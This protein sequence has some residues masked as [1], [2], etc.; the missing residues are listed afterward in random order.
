MGLPGQTDM[1]DLEGDR[2]GAVNHSMVG[3]RYVRDSGHQGQHVNGQH[4]QDLQHGEQAGEQ[5]ARVSDNRRAGVAGERCAGL[6]GQL[7][8]GL[9]GESRAG[10]ASD[11][12]AGHACGHKAGLA[13]SDLAQPA[14]GS[15]AGLTDEPERD[16]AVNRCMTGR[17]AHHHVAS[18]GREAAAEA[19]SLPAGRA[20]TQRAGEARESPG[21]HSKRAAIY[22]HSPGE[23]GGRVAG[24]TFSP[25]VNRRPT[26]PTSGGAACYD[27]TLPGE[28]NMYEVVNLVRKRSSPSPIRQCKV[29]VKVRCVG[30]TSICE[31]DTQRPGVAD[32]RT[33]DNDRC[34]CVTGRCAR[35]AGRCTRASCAYNRSSFPVSQDVQS[36]DCVECDTN[37][38]RSTDN[39]CFQTDKN[40]TATTSVTKR[41]SIDYTC[42]GIRRTS[43]DLSCQS[44]RRAS[45]D[46][47][48]VGGRRTSLDF[49]CIANRRVSKDHSYQGDRRSSA[50]L[51]FQG[52]RRTS[53]DL[54]CQGKRHSGEADK[55]AKA[56]SRNISADSR[57]TGVHQW[58][59]LSRICRTANANNV[60]TYCFSKHQAQH[61][62]VGLKGNAGLA[63][64]S[65]PP[66]ST[67][68]LCSPTGWLGEGDRQAGRGDTAKQTV[69]GLLSTVS[70]G[71]QEHIHTAKTTIEGDRSLRTDFVLPTYCADKEAT[72][73]R[74]AKVIKVARSI[75][76]QTNRE[77]S[78]QPVAV[79]SQPIDHPIYFDFGN[80]DFCQ[81]T[82]RAQV[83]SPATDRP[84]G[85]LPTDWTGVP[86]P[87]DHTELPRPIDQTGV[88]R[89][90]DH[91]GVLLTTDH[92]GHPSPAVQRG[93]HPPVEQPSA[94]LPADRTGVPRSTH[95]TGSQSEHL[96]RIWSGKEQG[97][98]GA[99]NRVML[100]PHP[101]SMVGRD[102]MTP[103]PHSVICHDVMSPQPQV[104]RDVSPQTPSLICRDVMMSPQFSWLR[105][106]SDRGPTA[107]CPAVGGRASSGVVHNESRRGRET[108]TDSARKSRE[109]SCRHGVSER[110]GA[111]CTEGASVR[112]I[113]FKGEG[114]STGN[115]AACSDK[116]LENHSAYR[117]P[118]QLCPDGCTGRQLQ[119]SGMTM[120]RR[121]QKGYVTV[122]T[123]DQQHRAVCG[124]EEKH[125]A[126]A[127][128]DRLDG[129]VVEC[130]QTDK[131]SVRSD[132]NNNNKYVRNDQTDKET[133]R[134]HQKDKAQM[135]AD[136]REKAVVGRD[137]SDWTA[138]KGN[139]KDR[140]TVRN[141]LKDK[142]TVKNDHKDKGPIKCDQ[143]DRAVA[144]CDQKDKV[145][146]RSKDNGTT[147]ERNSGDVTP[148][149]TRPRQQ[150]WQ[151]EGAINIS[152]NYLPLLDDRTLRLLSV[153]SGQP[154]NDTVTTHGGY[155]PGSVEPSKVTAHSGHPPETDVPG[156]TT[157]GGPLPGKDVRAKTTRHDGHLPGSVPCKVTRRDSGLPEVLQ[158]LDV[159]WERDGAVNHSMTGRCSADRNTCS[160]D[161]KTVSS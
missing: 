14:G 115:T 146:G 135:T 123:S 62:S 73:A 30:Q 50:D 23:G 118:H 16:G 37:K 95:Q 86:L 136:G 92:F 98:D 126:V 125:N 114:V 78:L 74:S 44:D 130:G 99:V 133:A 87:S 158:G 124:S 39:S 120:P 100:G 128:S 54:T 12:E 53:V 157:H 104:S 161:G 101:Y 47:T 145:V 57:W 112:N 27:V 4:H 106:H 28:T 63:S 9:A 94:S 121:D 159:Q 79:S 108:S 127:M 129:A 131:A 102:V 15:T 143:E 61:L 42:Q 52:V 36:S 66:C 80:P 58:S 85:P 75:Q 144:K 93:V 19:A 148:P 67:N 83:I 147:K 26:T 156:I 55:N 56:G 111:L 2:E 91:T 17:T 59:D 160:P 7:Q 1:W 45:V 97:R 109:A 10:L 22:A 139:P 6:A 48:R 88:P 81:L 134:C 29:Q 137:P 46:L 5:Q 77:R 152:M 21:G 151:R 82:T 13:E 33:G 103:Q 18:H 107:D 60:K 113:T 51:T 138:V 154:A 43:E 41:T 84:G 69:A 72:A 64:V 65:K 34:K 150:M 49:S 31:G 110:N 71:H 25:S 149:P 20:A 32:R 24:H 140:A 40:T 117:D 119:A 76:S 116:V 89:P 35:D 141:G 155:P 70:N 8:A 142:T 96:S 38:R 122:E 11:H 3:R 153:D 68:V 90:T 105:D 132:H